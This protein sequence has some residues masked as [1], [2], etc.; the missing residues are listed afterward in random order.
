MISQILFAGLILFVVLSFS[1]R[2]MNDQALTAL[3]SEN[4]KTVHSI[5]SRLR[6]L[7]VL[8]IVALLLLYVFLLSLTPRYF[9]P[10]ITGFLAVT[11]FWL[12]VLVIWAFVQLKKR[13]IPAD[14]LK[15]FL[16]SQLVRLAG[17]FILFALVIGRY[18]PIP[19]NLAP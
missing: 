15:R 19:G 11:F 7:S 18:V 14:Y 3:S 4:Q 8:P 6:F 1:A 10:V 5:L 13:E 12:A 9:S 2:L 17:F 16:L